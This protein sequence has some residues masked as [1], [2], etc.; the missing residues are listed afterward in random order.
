MKVLIFMSDNRPVSTKLESAE[1]NSLSAA[2]NYE[3]SKKH[4]YDFIYYRPYLHNTSVIELYNCLNPNSK[5]TRHAAWSKLL[6]SQKALESPYDYVVYLDSDCIFYNHSLKLEDYIKPYLDKSILFLND[7]PF[8][9]ENPC[10]GF[11]ICKVNDI[12]KG[13]FKEW[14][15]YNLPEKDK[16]H[17]WEQNALYKLLPRDFIQI[18]DDVMFEEKEGQYIR[19]IGTHDGGNRVPIFKG[20][21]ENNRIDFEKSILSIRYEDYSTSPNSSQLGGN[22]RLKTRKYYKKGKH[23]RPSLKRRRRAVPLSA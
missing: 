7:Y 23:S 3:Y 19:H 14:Y 1:Y 15:S 9:K 20:F 13:F 21:I 4:G 10:S 11:Y 5:E 18:I 16:E 22:Y 6:S 17:A 12:S 2:I 8:S